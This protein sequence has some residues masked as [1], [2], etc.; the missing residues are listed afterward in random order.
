[1]TKIGNFMPLGLKGLPDIA[2]LDFVSDE[3]TLTDGSTAHI[4]KYVDGRGEDTHNPVNAVAIVAGPWM[5]RYIAMQL[6]DD[7]DD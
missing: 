3:V 1:M 7:E 6:P 4:I 5:G 2:R